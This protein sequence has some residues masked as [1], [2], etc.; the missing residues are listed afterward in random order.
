MPSPYSDV[1]FWNHLHTLRDGEHVVGRNGTD[2]SLLFSALS[3]FMPPRPT[4]SL[5]R[6]GWLGD[7]AIASYT[8]LIKQQFLNEKSTFVHSLMVDK[9]RE[10]CKQ[11]TWSVFASILPRRHSIDSTSVLYFLSNV[12]ACHWILAVFEHLDGVPTLSVMDSWPEEDFSAEKTSL[13]ES[14]G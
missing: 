12:G 14:L 2:K 4:Q 10:I 9:I 11:K 7:T 13:I 5:E 3:E 1:N 8:Q 6:Q